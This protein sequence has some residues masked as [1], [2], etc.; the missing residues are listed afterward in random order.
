MFGVY[1]GLDHVTSLTVVPKEAQI[2]GNVV[3][4]TQVV[5]VA[6][7]PGLSHQVALQTDVPIIRNNENMYPHS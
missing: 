1:V 5:A 6:V 3:H 2:D 4:V 7:V